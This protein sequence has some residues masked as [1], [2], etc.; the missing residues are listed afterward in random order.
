MV[1]RTADSS[2]L[3]NGRASTFSSA[4]DQTIQHEQRLDGRKIAIVS[5]SANSWPVIEPFVDRIAAAVA[6][7]TPGS[8][9]PDC[10]RQVNRKRRP[11]VPE[12]A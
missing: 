12:P 4:A 1:F 5:L 10:M 2:M 6:A 11:P 7:T 3:L 9:V 8:F